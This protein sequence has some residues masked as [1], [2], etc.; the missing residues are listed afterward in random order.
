MNFQVFLLLFSM[1]LQNAANNASKEGVYT[2]QSCLRLSPT[3]PQQPP[4]V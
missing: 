1:Q 2:K 4:R 3:V